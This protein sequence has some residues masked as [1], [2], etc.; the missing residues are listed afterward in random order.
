MFRATKTPACGDT[1]PVLPREEVAGPAPRQQPGRGGC[2]ASATSSWRRC[3]S[4]D[5]S[6]RFAALIAGGVRAAAPS[7][8]R[9][10]VDGRRR[11]VRSSLG[12]PHSSKP[13]AAPSDEAPKP[14]GSQTVPNSCLRTGVSVSAD[15][16]DARRFPFRTNSATSTT[17]ARLP[18]TEP[19]DMPR[20]LGR[21]P[22]PSHPRR[23][24]RRMRSRA[25][26]E[27][28]G[29]AHTK[30]RRSK[31]QVGA[32]DASQSDRP[33]RGRVGRANRVTCPA[34]GVRCGEADRPR[35]LPQSL[36]RRCDAVDVAWACIAAVIVGSRAARA[37]GESAGAGPRRCTHPA[38]GEVWGVIAA[39]VLRAAAKAASFQR[40][41]VVARGG[42][43]PGSVIGCRRKI[44]AESPCHQW[45]ASGGPIAISV[46]AGANLRNP[47]VAQ[48][49]EPVS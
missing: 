20:P 41:R 15:D 5:R 29:A 46:I 22:S 44:R 24:P 14:L 43:R 27:L 25:V 8:G 21:R 7:R 36:T 1:K 12:P 34:G 11:G 9:A 32:S 19:A 26:G 3:R 33:A 35:G 6:G 38:D 2:F 40:P 13:S 45:S 10:E 16:A 39:G 31:S 28:S 42:A 47:G 17:A 30:R 37:S 48:V 4:R 49:R 23:P 18:Q